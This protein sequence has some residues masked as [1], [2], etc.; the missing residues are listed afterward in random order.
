MTTLLLSAMLATSAVL[1]PT[2]VATSAEQSPAMAAADDIAAPLWK[3][4][5]SCKKH[6]TLPWC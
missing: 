4:I 6:P 2:M 5:L 3:D 1:S